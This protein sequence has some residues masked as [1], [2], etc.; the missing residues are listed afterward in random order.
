MDKYYTP[1]LQDLY[2]GYEC[3]VKDIPPPEEDWHQWVIT[4]TNVLHH[5]DKWIKDGSLRTKYLTQEDIES[6]GWKLIPYEHYFEK[7]NY[8][9]I[10]QGEKIEIWVKDLALYDPEGETTNGTIF[11]G[12]AKSINE[13]KKIMEWIL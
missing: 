9:M 4:T 7:D 5:L 8:I 13:L 11:K 2:V 6:L 12:E 3:E 1:E 10:Q